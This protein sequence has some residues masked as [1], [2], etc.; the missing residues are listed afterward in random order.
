MR[1]LC[2]AERPIPLHFHDPRAAAICDL[3]QKVASFPRLTTG[4]W[5][6]T[7]AAEVPQMARDRLPAG[8]KPPLRSFPVAAA[9]SNVFPGVVVFSRLGTVGTA[10][11][12]I[13]THALRWRAAASLRAQHQPL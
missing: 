2:L 5:A 12:T 9:I 1:R 13:F 10:M 3:E 11:L 8:P 6:L 4:A 7:Y